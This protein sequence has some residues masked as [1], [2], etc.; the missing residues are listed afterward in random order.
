MNSAQLQP[1]P[2]DAKCIEVRGC[3]VH[4]LDQVDVDLPLH[5]LILFTGVSGSGK[6]SL[7]FDTLFV[8]GQR[9]YIE[10]FST[11]ARQFF[12]QLEKPDADRISSIP[13][14]IAI[15]QNALS[16]SGRSTVGTQTEILDYLRIVFAR[17]GERYCPDCQR[18]LRQDSIESSLSRVTDLE[19]GTRYLITFP[20]RITSGAAPLLRSSGFRRVISGQ[21]MLNVDQLESE[22]AGFDGLVVVDRLTAGKSDSNRIRDSLEVA[23]RAGKLRWQVLVASP[24]QADLELDGR[25][26][27]RWIFDVGDCCSHCGREVPQ[28]DPRL[29]SFSSPLGA[30]PECNGFGS[31]RSI[32]W[33]RLVPD[34]GL[35][36]NEGAIGCWNSPSY[37]HELHELQELADDWGV[38]LDVPFSEVD[39]ASRQ[40]I[41][42]GVPERQFGGLVGFFNWLERRKYKVGIRSMLS[43]WRS[44]ETCPDCQ[45]TRLQPAARAVRFAGKTLS[46]LTSLPICDLRSALQSAREGLQP[47]ERAVA[48]FPLDEALARLEY[49]NLVGL[50]YLTLDRTIRTLSGGEAQRVALTS[51]LG[52]KLVNTLFV[53]DEPTSGLHPRDTELV[54]QATE[55]LRDRKNT[56]VVVEHD[57]GF[58]ARA[59]WIVEFGPG[60]GREG[61][62]IVYAGEPAGLTEVEESAT[63]RCYLRQVKPTTVETP[64]RQPIGEVTVEG[65]TRHNLRDVNLR[66]PLGVLCGVTGVS[67]SGKSTLVD[68]SLYASV[69]R[70]LGQPVVLDEA[71]W[72]KSVS[73]CELLEEVQLVDQKP[74]GRSSRSN[75]VTYVKAFDEIRKLFAATEEARLRNL[76][77][78]AFSFNSSQGG[79]CQRCLGQGTVE[80]D[81]HFLGQLNMTCPECHGR[82]YERE[83]LEV[84]SRGLNISEVLDLT[85]REAYSV[86][87]SE[88]GL[89][90]K[91]QVLVDVGLDYLPLGQSTSTLSGGEIQRLKLAG[92]LAAQRSVRKTGSRL[93]ILDEPTIG[94]HRAD[95]VRLV[96]CLHRLVEVGDSV[97]VVE[98]DLDLIQAC[99]VVIEMGPAAGDQGGQIVC[100]GS[101]AELQ[102]E[103]NSLTGRY[104]SQLDVDH[105]ADQ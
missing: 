11:Y 80:V 5:R 99:D 42:N 30:C 91:L 1:S 88:L 78:S 38:P 3:R 94:L 105:F 62:R 26:W 97:V 76:K 13:P 23:A 12:D 69:A 36:I 25:H 60:A 29:F 63:A 31:R 51:A 71:P 37:V 61:G 21:R 103:S 35:S 92:Q 46:D 77:P 27:E 22:S 48:E 79:R 85:V 83:I 49:L 95:I 70:E 87:R 44:Y 54:V 104:L 17:A 82:R 66:I 101:P 89:L 41:M 75:A 10:S 90:R 16:R 52:S 102:A 84:S 33:H 50:D 64:Q 4:N 53:L 58:I 96:Q 74:L 59:D 65:I 32:S 57:A 68:E 98:H 40:V 19:S 28:L 43:R 93:L 56:V 81:L 7:A 6:S 100:M 72:W 14:A 8:D 45:G 67:G 39:E 47:D 2:A 55:M 15:R 86:F 73:G 24:A 34:P 9:R 20:L 18:P